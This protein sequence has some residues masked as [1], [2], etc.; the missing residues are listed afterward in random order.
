[1]AVVAISDG[2]R[3]TPSQ[4][5]LSFKKVRRFDSNRWLGVGGPIATV[6][7]AAVVGYWIYDISGS[8]RS[9][10]TLAGWTCVAVLVLGLVM[11][12]I[13]SMVPSAE[14]EVSQSQRGGDRSLNL[15]AGRD[16]RIDDH[17]FRRRG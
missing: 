12:G 16:V 11:L 17:R 15:Q 4:R 3:A 10:W 1:M 14:R 2:L 6:A 8:H 13:G 5:F 9:F 7:G